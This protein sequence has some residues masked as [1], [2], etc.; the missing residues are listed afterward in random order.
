MH[1]KNFSLLQTNS[2]YILSPFYDLVPTR[3]I[4]PE[5][6]EETAL[7]VNGKKSRLT[8][9]DFTDLGT[10]LNLHSKVIDNLMQKAVNL[11]EILN[12]TPALNLLPLERHEELK[13]I[14]KERCGRL[15]GSC[16]VKS[17]G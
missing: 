5:D 13:A 16:D 8:R 15:R 11:F 3:I 12:K 17:Q 2:G 14:V 9:K 4:I 7:T 6:T 1:L 10:S